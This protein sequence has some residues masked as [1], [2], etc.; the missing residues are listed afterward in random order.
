[1]KV[2]PCPTI[3]GSFPG[4]KHLCNGAEHLR[5]IF[6]NLV[7]TV[8]ML[9]KIF[10]GFWWLHMK[11]TIV[12]TDTGHTFYHYMF[13]NPIFL[14]LCKQTRIRIESL[15][16]MWFNLALSSQ[17][18][19]SCC[20]KNEQFYNRNNQASLL[21]NDMILEFLPWSVWLSYFRLGATFFF[22]HEVIPH[23]SLIARVLRILF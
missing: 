10:V 16:Y 13:Y 18:S 20:I 7:D 5:G 19:W 1:M 15:L 14:H 17:W 21:K 9:L 4:I 6:L 12:W 22:L 11:R 2:M 23:P 3:P 8:I